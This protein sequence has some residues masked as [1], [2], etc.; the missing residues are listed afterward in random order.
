MSDVATRPLAPTVWI[1]RTVPAAFKSAA[2]WAN[3]GYAAAVGPILDVTKPR[4]MPALPPRD[5]IVIFTSSNAAKSFAEHTLNRQWSVVTVGFQTKHV[6]HDLGFR[7]VIT[8]NGSSED[9]TRLILE[10]YT[11]DRPI[12][13]CAGNHVRGTIIED[14]KEKGYR[15][16]RDLY[17]LTT[18][19]K[20]LPKIDTAKLDFVTLYS[21]LAAE[22]LLS[23]KPDLTGVTILSLSQAIDDVFGDYPCKARYVA[24]E[25]SELSLID[26]VPTV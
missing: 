10:T 14:L 22:T 1:T 18:P 20:E 23:F 5:G 16:Q 15:A 21:P 19:V 25:P 26:A 9:V 4:E 13:H 6:C 11:T 2:N 12:Y 8:A 17:Y 3:A 24:A 7:D